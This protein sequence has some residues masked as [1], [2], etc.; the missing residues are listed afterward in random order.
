MVARPREETATVVDLKSGLPQLTLDAPMKVYGLRVV[1]NADA[2]IGDGVIITW[3]LPKG[4]YL[5]HARVGIENS[6][7]TTS[8]SGGGKSQAITTSISLDFRYVAI[9]GTGMESQFPM[10]H[11]Y[12]LSTG[13]NVYKSF[14][15]VA[16]GSLW[17][18]PSGLDIWFAPESKVE[19]HPIDQEEHR[20]SGFNIEDGPCGSPWRPSCGCTVTNNGWLIGPDGKWLF[21]LPPP[22][23]S[24]AASGYG[25]DN[26][27]RYCA[28]H[29]LN[30]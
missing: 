2:V 14:V 7:Q 10:L 5:P 9:L 11:A 26:L 25:T 8:F 4:D 24:Y 18:V 21:V 29:Y 23:R 1:D 16:G 12:S 22:W 20:L 17:F 6:T 27:S 13:R 28:T 15:L 19:S 30:L 3:N